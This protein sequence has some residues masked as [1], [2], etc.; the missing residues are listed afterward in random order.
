[1][2]AGSQTGTPRDTL[3]PC[4]WTCSFGW[5]LAEGYWNR[6]QR[7]PMGPCGLERTLAFGSVN[8]REPLSCFFYPDAPSRY[9][10]SS[11]NLCGQFSNESD[12]ER[13]C[14]TT[15]DTLISEN[16]QW[17]QVLLAYDVYAVCKY[18]GSWCES[19]TK[20][21]LP[22]RW[23]SCVQSYWHVRQ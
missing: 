11:F 17:A 22:W 4:P 1:M 16:V 18:L 6:D 21:R 10:L 9:F 12:Y 2:H 3:A 15:W 23:S 14:L 7:R 13:F 5:C 19:P 8:T 20:L